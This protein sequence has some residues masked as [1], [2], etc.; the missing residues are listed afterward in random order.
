MNQT[1]TSTKI[2][3]LHCMSG[4]FMTGIIWFVQIVHYPLFSQVS[5]GNFVRYEEQHTLLTTFVVLPPMFIELITATCL[6]RMRPQFL[7]QEQAVVVFTTTALIWLLTFL[8]HVPQ[9]NT[10]GRGFSVELHA[11]LVSTNWGRTVLW[12]LKSAFLTWLLQRAMVPAESNV[13]IRFSAQAMRSP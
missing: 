3:L 7:N 9:H 8:A 12:T 1:G 13:P 10:L 2:F 4:L 11:A 6:L 5:P